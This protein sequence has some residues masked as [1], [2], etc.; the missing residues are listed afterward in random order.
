MSDGPIT[1]EKLLDLMIDPM[2][3]LEDVEISARKMRERLAVIP[4]RFQRRI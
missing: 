1:D 3:E 4:V 2:A